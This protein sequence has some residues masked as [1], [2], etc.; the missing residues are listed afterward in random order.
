MNTR[1]TITLAEI[2]EYKTILNQGFVA[3]SLKS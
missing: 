3:Q 2:D 1:Q